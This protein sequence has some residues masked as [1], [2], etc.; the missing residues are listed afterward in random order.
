MYIY[1]HSVY[2]YTF[3]L[4]IHWCAIYKLDIHGL[5]CGGLEFSCSFLQWLPFVSVFSEALRTGCGVFIVKSEMQYLHKWN[6][7]KYSEVLKMIAANCE[8]LLILSETRRNMGYLCKQSLGPKMGGNKYCH[9]KWNICKYSEVL[10]MIAANCESLLILS[11]T[12][13]NMG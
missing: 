7:C 10:K 9:H 8:S 4:F 3:N 6:I 12:R 5:L 11:E 1:I 13:R 2:L